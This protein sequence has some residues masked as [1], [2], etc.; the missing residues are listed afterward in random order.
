LLTAV[1]VPLSHAKCCIVP[2]SGVE[3]IL[4]TGVANALAGNDRIT[5]TFDLDSD[6]VFK[7]VGV[8]NTDDGNDTITGIGS[9]VPYYSN[10]YGISNS[11]TFNTAEGDDVITGT[12]GRVGI[13]NSGTFNTAEGDDIITADAQQGGSGLENTGTFNTGE[14]NDTI[15]ANMGFGVGL[16]NSGTFNT[17]EGD[18]VITCEGYYN[19]ILTNSSSIF[20]TGDGNDKIRGNSNE[21]SNFPT[22]GISNYS[23]TFNTGDGN[24]TIEGSGV[25]GIYNAALINT[26]NGKDG[27]AD[28]WYESPFW[29]MLQNSP[30]LAYSNSN[31]LNSYLYSA[32]PVLCSLHRLTPPALRFL[33]IKYQ[34]E[35]FFV[36]I[37]GMFTIALSYASR[38]TDFAKAASTKLNFARIG[39]SIARLGWVVDQC[40]IKPS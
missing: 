6:I 38:S 36:L 28:S 30:Y 13:S 1:T 35:F 26:G 18:D 5:G 4:N 2:P 8:L 9:S 29:L 15:T 24:D 39:C 12:A 20:D 3:Q 7:N 11:G 40:N 25:Y 32:T 23:S 16:D 22:S 33:R 14:G 10:A 31:I 37:L 34:T 17:A 19:G 27:V 21:S